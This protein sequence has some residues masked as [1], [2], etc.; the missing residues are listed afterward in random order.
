[1]LT[2][3]YSTSGKIILSESGKEALCYYTDDV[4]SA[5]CSLYS[6]ETG[7]FW[8]ADNIMHGDRYIGGMLEHSRWFPAPGHNLPHIDG[9]V[10]GEGHGVNEHES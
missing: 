4:L 9:I 2:K 1:M 7:S 6:D 10:F 8:S 3:K 5:H